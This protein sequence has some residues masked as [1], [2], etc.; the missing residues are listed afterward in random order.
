[1]GSRA[2]KPLTDRELEVLKMAAC[3][4]SNARITDAL[5]LSE[6]TV[7]RHLA[8][9][10]EKL[11]ES[12]RNEAVSVALAG[13]VARMDGPP[14]A[15]WPR[16][17]RGGRRVAKGCRLPLRG[18]RLRARGRGG[19]PH[20]RTELGRAPFVPRPQDGAGGAAIG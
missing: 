12:S 5:H 16:S 10:Y 4:L 15:R 20:V 9:V 17:R 1:V 18:A 3:G 13:G 11:G 7:K 14:A 6:A 8:N 2:G 19:A